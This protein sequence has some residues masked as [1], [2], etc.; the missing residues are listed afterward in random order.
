MSAAKFTIKKL[1]N[2]TQLQDDLAF[3]DVNLSSAMMGQ[4]SLFAHYAQISADAT[5]QVDK[6]KQMRD[7]IIA[8]VDKTI[9]DK[10]AT[11]GKKVTE[12]LIEKEVDL[13]PEVVAMKHKVNEASMVADLAKNALEAFKQRKDMLIQIGV[14]LREEMKGSVSVKGPAA[15]AAMDKRRQDMADRMDKH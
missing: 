3:S 6:A 4:A 9:R 11:E 14:A 12:K 7:I 2:P 13:H 10:Y 15:D 5:G 8:K 1:I